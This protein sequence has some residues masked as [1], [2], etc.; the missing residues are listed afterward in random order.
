MFKKIILVSALGLSLAMSQSALAGPDSDRDRPHFGPSKHQSH[1]G[2][3]QWKDS[4]KHHAKQHH[5]AHRREANRHHQQYHQQQHRRDHRQAHR[6]YRRQWNSHHYRAPA[7]RSNHGHSNHRWHRGHFIP[8]HY[9]GHR[10]VVHDY[11]HHHL[12]HPPRGYHWVRV[13]RDFILVAI[14]SGLIA[15]VIYGGY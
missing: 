10:Y 8:H 13:D 2:G 11:H 7:Y 12:H 4:H 6:D 14:T 1:H 5:K 15:S 9:R 3:K